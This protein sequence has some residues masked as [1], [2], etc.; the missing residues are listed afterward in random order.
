[1][2]WF[3]FLGNN[4]NISVRTTA[5]YNAMGLGLLPGTSYLPAGWKLSEIAA[6]PIFHGIEHTNPRFEKF[7]FQKHSKIPFGDGQV[8]DLIPTLPGQRS[9]I[10]NVLLGDT[11]C[12]NI[13]I[14]RPPDAETAKK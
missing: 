7:L 2:F 1:M 5:F 4:V 8:Q 13:E 14:F 10:Q 12:F 6:N 3:F 11:K 9:L